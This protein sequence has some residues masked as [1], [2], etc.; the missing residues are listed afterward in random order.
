MLK[1]ER[2]SGEVPFPGRGAAIGSAEMRRSCQDKPLSSG[3]QRG[4]A[5]SEVLPTLASPC[6]SRSSPRE[7]IDMVGALAERW[8]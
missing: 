6:P 1:R 8:F 2:G 5:K 7:L 4:N 3:S